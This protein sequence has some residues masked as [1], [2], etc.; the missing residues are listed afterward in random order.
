MPRFTFVGLL[1]ALAVGIPVAATAQSSAK[2]SAPK[3]AAKKSPKSNP[4]SPASSKEGE[5]V[6][7]KTEGAAVDKIKTID[8]KIDSED[9]ASPSTEAT[10][11][12]TAQGEASD[13]DRSPRAEGRF[14]IASLI[15]SLGPYG[16]VRT[17]D[18]F[19]A[20]ETLTYRF[21]IDQPRLNGKREFNLAFSYRL[22]DEDGKSQLAESFPVEGRLWIDLERVRYHLEFKLPDDLSPGKYSLEVSCIDNEAGRPATIAKPLEVKPAEFALVSTRFYYDSATSIPAPAGGLVGQDLFFQVEVLGE[23]RSA[24]KAH[25]VFEMQ[26]LDESGENVSHLEPVSWQHDSPEFVRDR[27]KHP[28]FSGHLSLLRSGNFILRLLATDKATGETTSQDTPLRV[29]PA[30][31]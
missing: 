22:L 11:S 9:S 12:T 30:P 16:P 13:A 3:S 24:N 15:P 1:A 10:D 5:R 25:L 27:S 31:E 18:A 4:K 21:D 7:A 2:K 29:S 26:V 19:Y 14:E 17:G 20:G 6:A 23:D 28:L 8:R